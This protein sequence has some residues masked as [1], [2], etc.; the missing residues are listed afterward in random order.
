MR[1][2]L[3]LGLGALLLGVLSGCS[4][5]TQQA[6]ALFTP[7]PKPTAQLD[8]ESAQVYVL[9]P[10]KGVS[11]RR[12]FETPFVSLPGM[13]DERPL[14]VSAR[15]KQRVVDALSRVVLRVSNERLYFEVQIVEAQAGWRAHWTTEEAYAS[16]ALRICVMDGLDHTGLL[17][18]NVT[19]WAY[20][21]SADVTDH[22][23]A[24]LLDAAV[25][26][27]WTRWLRT[28]R[29][30]DAINRKLD[31]KHRTGSVPE[32]ERCSR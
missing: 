17:T 7:L 19:G 25:V 5:T 16:T 15:A 12:R 18:N 24:D 14:A 26:D 22:E 27:T 9:D 32:V 29:A 21:W 30:I 28:D 20:R 31:E 6:G 11:T 4:G 10:R 3:G 13:H 23:S 2:I 1:S 8:S